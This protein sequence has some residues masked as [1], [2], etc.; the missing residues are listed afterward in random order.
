MNMKV[1]VLKMN[2]YAR[3]S[4]SST[5]AELQDHIEKQNSRKVAGVR[6]G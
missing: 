3:N 1:K 4:V 2:K 5:Y 6:N